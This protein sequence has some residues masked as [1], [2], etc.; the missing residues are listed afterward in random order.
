LF[1]ATRFRFD[2]IDDVTDVVRKVDWVTA[3]G[4]RDFP[5]GCDLESYEEAVRCYCE[6]TSG[7]TA[8]VYQVGNVKYPGLS[9]I[10][11][12]VVVD[13]PVW[14]NNQYF[15]PFVRLR[16]KH[17]RLFH[18]DPRM[19]P[20]PVI[21]AISL[22]SC[23]HAPV[24]GP[25]DAPQ[26]R[27]GSRRRLIRGADVLGARTPLSDSE[28]WPRCRVLETAF[29]Y[30]R[31]L[32]AFDAESS[33]DVTHVVSRAASLRHPMRHLDD[34]L[35]RAQDE[36]YGVALDERRVTLLDDAVP[37]ESKE[38]AAAEVMEL[39]RDACARFEAGVRTLF[40][41]DPDADIATT[42]AEL[43]SGRIPVKG[44]DPA[45]MAA[46]HKWL[47]AYH[48]VLRDYRFSSGSIFAIKP[49]DGR[50]RAYRQP[51]AERIVAGIAYRL[52]PSQG[53]RTAR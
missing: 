30:R 2:R 9:D 40:D 36:S 6:A 43:L 22:S 10:D 21:D 15:S 1:V 32:D 13:R 53:A 42:A 47:E 28:N 44:I 19:V 33:I 38:R 12:V 45:Y 16:S 3:S 49:Y 23:G 17:R 24:A 37:D 4:F 5:R 51:I 26:D 39:F 18:H 34:L 8:A 41:I 20:I 50:Y 27:F 14:D 29:L 46:R 48:A 25:T 7:R 31:A 52:R 11:L 35:G